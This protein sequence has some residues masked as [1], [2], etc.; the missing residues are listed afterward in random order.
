MAIALYFAALLSFSTRFSNFFR[1][2]LFFPYLIN[3]VAIGFVFLYLFQPGRHARH[4]ARLGRRRR[5]ARSG[6]ATRRRQLLPRRHVAS[7][8][9]P[10]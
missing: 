5:A 3:G 1:G 4:G 9:T 10:A 8:G 7:G 6:W 2:I